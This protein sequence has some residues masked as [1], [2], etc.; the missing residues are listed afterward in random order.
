MKTNRTLLLIS[1]LLPVSTFFSCT[2]LYSP[3]SPHLPM[4]NEKGVTEVNASIGAGE[5][6]A[7]VDLNL[8]HS[9]SDHAGIMI[10]YSTFAGASDDKGCRNIDFGAGYFTPIEK[11]GGFETYAIIGYGANDAYETT[12]LRLALQP[13]IFYS[14]KHFEAAFGLRM[15]Y[16]N[17]DRS[18]GAYPDDYNSPTASLQA[19][20]KFL[21]IEPTMKLTVGGEKVKFSMQGTY[22]TEVTGN[23]MDIDPYVLSFG[24]TFKFPA[25]RSRLQ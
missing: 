19:N 17:Y 14:G 10:N 18:F 25:G 13:D 24:L 6:V 16:L 21:T 20:N 1:T 4:I 7:C 15:Q 2:P 23:Y 5:D 22:S 11:K 9:V 12:C 8:A 3:T